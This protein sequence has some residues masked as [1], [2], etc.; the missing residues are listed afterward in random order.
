MSGL[1]LL[2]VCNV[3]RI[4]GGMK[5]EKASRTSPVT[6]RVGRVEVDPAGARSAP[7]ERAAPSAAEAPPTTD[8]ATW[9]VE[10]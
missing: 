4:V 5:L 7:R 8:A 1:R 3:G 6:Y 9:R 2:Q 10:L